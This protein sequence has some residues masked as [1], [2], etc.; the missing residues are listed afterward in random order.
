[1]TIMRIFVVLLEPQRME[2]SLL[3]ANLSSAWNHLLPH[4]AMGV[5]PLAGTRVIDNRWLKRREVKSIHPRLIQDRSSGYGR[6]RKLPAA[7]E[8]AIDGYNF[9]PK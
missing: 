7:C 3:I 9:R 4:A 8:A 1:M 2:I 5:A 6:K